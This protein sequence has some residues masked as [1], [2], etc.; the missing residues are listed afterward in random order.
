MPKRIIRDS[1][2]AWVPLDSPNRKPG[3]NYRA[4]NARLIRIRLIAEESR[5]T[6]LIVGT[7]NGRFS[8]TL[9]WREHDLARIDCGRR[10]AFR[11]RAGASREYV[12]G[13]HIHYFVAGH[14]LDYARTTS[15]YSFDDVN[16]ALVFFA[17]HCGVLRLP[18]VQETLRL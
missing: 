10:H 6:F 15:E 13:P 4:R 11:E 3:K 1:D 2:V 18:P 7:A 9:K 16:G 12:E 17:R 14:G 5:E 8:F